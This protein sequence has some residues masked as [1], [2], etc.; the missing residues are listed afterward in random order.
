[1]FN[2]GNTVRRT[3]LC[4][5]AL[6]IAGCPYGLKPCCIPGTWLLEEVVLMDGQPCEEGTLTP[7]GIMTFS[8]DGT[9]ELEQGNYGLGYPWPGTWTVADS[10]ITIV[11]E[12]VEEFGF[13]E[14]TLVGV[15]DCNTI[16]FMDGDCVT[17]K[18]R[19]IVYL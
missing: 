11:L 3:A 7:T 8:D 4:A 9:V 5:V 10:E 12:E 19:K 15:V 13:E 16:E 18:L 1:M 14:M 6:L 17:A 2:Q